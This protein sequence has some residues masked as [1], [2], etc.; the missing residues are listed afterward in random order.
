[1]LKAELRAESR[2]MRFHHVP[3]FRRA[4]MGRRL[5]T[6]QH[7]PFRRRLGFN[8]VARMLATVVAKPDRPETDRPVRVLEAGVGKGL[9]LDHLLTVE[10]GAHI[11]FYGFDISDTS[12]AVERLTATHP[13]EA[14]SERILS[15]SS[16]R[17]P[18]ADGLFDVVI[19]NQVLEHVE[20]LPNFLHECRRVLRNDGTAIHVFP[21][22]R[23]MI[24]SHLFI[25]YVHRLASDR[26]RLR[27]LNA[28]YRIG[29][30]KG[31]PRAAREAANDVRYLREST[32][33][34]IWEDIAEAASAKGFLCAPRRSM[35]YLTASIPLASTRPVSLGPR[36]TTLR[37]LCSA[38][39][40]ERLFSITLLLWP[41]A[42]DEEMT[43]NE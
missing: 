19:S 36:R 27:L 26:S 16:H 1:M 25:P 28:L 20:D 12:D 14:W 41:M 43:P 22:L 7:P 11:E 4:S 35:G 23:M 39:V 9:M 38:F 2:L 31:G 40:A 17:W 3:D 30:K 32:H 24:E 42:I 13:S 34:R 21:T 8:H 5:L 6:G 33:Y 10:L 29:V 18:F 37:D 15:A